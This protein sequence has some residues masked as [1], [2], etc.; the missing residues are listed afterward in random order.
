[1]KAVLGLVLIGARGSGKTTVG[2]ALASRLDLPFIDT[3]ALAEAKSGC[4]IA[5]IFEER[6]EEGFR[7]VEREVVESLEPGR[8]QVIASG[9][10]AV[11]DRSNRARLREIGPVAWLTGSVATL[12]ARIAGSERPSLTGTAPEVEVADVLAA[13][14]RHYADLATWVVDTDGRS[15]GEICD[16]LEQL[17]RDTQDHDLR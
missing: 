16:E 14:E 3:D 8:R 4:S 9:G 17:W 10:G 12:A 5:R 13:R 6:G 1:V 2:R 11:L 7:L 15:P